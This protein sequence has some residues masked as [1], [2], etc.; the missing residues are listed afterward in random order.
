MF[1]STIEKAVQCLA[2][3]THENFD[4]NNLHNNS[5]FKGNTIAA[6][7]TML[8]VISILLFFGKFLWNNVMTELFSNKF[9]NKCDSIWKI[10]GLYILFGMLFSK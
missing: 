4:I 3:D 6:F 5:H 7:I 9:V 1:V 2:N 10:L 8:I